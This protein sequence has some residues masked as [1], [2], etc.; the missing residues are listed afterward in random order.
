MSRTI[1]M[2]EFDVKRLRELI[3]DSDSAEYRGS[4]YIDHLRGELNRA[5][6][7]LPQEIPA[8]VITMNSRAILQ[9]ADSGDEMMLT[10][11]FP[12]DAD[13]LQDK[14]SVL[15]PI[16]TAIL[17]YREGDT[18]EWEVPDGTRRLVVKKI[19]YQPEASGDM[20]L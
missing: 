11:V 2:T 1:Y 5:K 6:I 10:L 4:A 20:D 15:A 16:G 19:V 12:Q 8:D 3:R 14:I 17:G 18:I 9:D 13:V 7:V